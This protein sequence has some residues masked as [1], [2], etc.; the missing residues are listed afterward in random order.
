M[1]LLGDQFVLGRSIREAIS[2]SAAFE[3]RGF[4]FSYDMLGEAAKTE[5]DATRYFERYMGAIDAVGHAARPEPALASGFCC[6]RVPSLSGQAVRA[7]SALR[8]GQGNAPRRELYPRVLELLKSAEAHGLAVTIDAE[9]Q[10]RH[11]LM[12]DIF[13]RAYTDP[14]LERW[15]GLGLAVQAYGK[16][17]IPT[18]RWLRRLA[19][20][21]GKRIPCAS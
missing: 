5:R 13:A 19:E 14:A 2:R 11:E 12:L 18:I 15:T 17:A 1:K 3:A 9:E 21:G 20:L 10:D 16:R 7:S 6:S 8:G 4:R